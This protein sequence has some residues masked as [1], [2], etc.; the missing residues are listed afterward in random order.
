MN[1]RTSF[2]FSEYPRANSRRA[3][4]ESYPKGEDG[5][6]FFEM[7]AMPLFDQ[8]YNCAHWLTGDTSEAE[9]LMRETYAKAFRGLSHSRKAPIYEAGCTSCAIHFSL[10]AVA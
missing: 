2:G 5:P 8:L 4:I 3:R 1:E 7:P 9:D 6:E 10:R